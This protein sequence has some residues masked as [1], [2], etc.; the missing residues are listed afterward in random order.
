MFTHDLNFVRLLIDEYRKR[1]GK[2]CLLIGL[3]SDRGFSGIP[4][5]EI[6]YL[7]KNIQERIDTIIKE[8]KVIN[9]ISPTQIDIIDAKTEL[10]YKRMRFLLE[11]TIED[12][13][14]NRTIQRFSKN[15]KIKAKQLS[16]FVVTE[17]ADIDF[18]LLLYGKYSTTEHDGGV[19]SENQK[20]TLDDVKKDL[21]EYDN[22]KK[23]FKTREQQ[24]ISSSGY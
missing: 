16:S 2:D 7:A 24:F 3:K 12:I 18:I 15:I 22:W 23:D 9:G 19:T 10:I 14:A 11:K 4:T 21:S 13:L 17:K 20:P 5:D 8:L 1:T 6:P